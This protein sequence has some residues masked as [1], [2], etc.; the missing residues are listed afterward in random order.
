VPEGGREGK[1]EEE[2][3]RRDEQRSGWVTTTAILR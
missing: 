1:D 2:K 3:E